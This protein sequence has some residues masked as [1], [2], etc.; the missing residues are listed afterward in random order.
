MVYWL[1]LQ[2]GGVMGKGDTYRK[3]T[4]QE[5]RNFDRNYLRLYGEECPV[6][7]GGK[8]EGKCLGCDGLGYVERNRKKGVS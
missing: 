8:L 3:Q 5:K 6:C 4:K 7:F 2:C 1:V